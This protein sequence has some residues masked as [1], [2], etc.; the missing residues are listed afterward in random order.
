MQSNSKKRQYLII[1]HQRCG[2]HY[3]ASILNSNSEIYQY[4]EFLYPDFNKDGFFYFL[5]HE[6]VDDKEQ[7]LI[8]NHEIVEKVFSKYFALAANR[9]SQGIVGFDTK[10]NLISCF[11]ALLNAERIYNIYGF[12]VIHLYRANYLDRVVSHLLMNRRIEEGDLEI[13]SSSIPS[14]RTISVDCESVINWIKTDMNSDSFINRTFAS[15]SHRYKLISYEEIT[16]RDDEKRRNCIKELLKFIDVKD[17]FEF[18]ES[19][20]A[21]QTPWSKREIIENCDELAQFLEKHSLSEFLQ[22]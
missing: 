12:K 6:I 14:K 2:S 15:D 9:V 7:L 5:L 16:D 11:P 22:N 18:E 21:K 17:P 19:K 20:L 10:I 1:S 13:H 4:G 8:T 3:L